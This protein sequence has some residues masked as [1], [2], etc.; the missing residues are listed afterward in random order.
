MQSF[1]H[2]VGVPSFVCLQQWCN[3]NMLFNWF[4]F[5]QYLWSWVPP[6]GWWSCEIFPKRSAATRN[7]HKYNEQSSSGSREICLVMSYKQS[8]VWQINILRHLPKEVRSNS[9]S[10]MVYKHKY[11]RQWSWEICCEMWGKNTSTSNETTLLWIWNLS[12]WDF[13]L[14]FAY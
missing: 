2:L 13:K 8:K 5:L 14:H 7:N 6:S 11:N 12:L 10:T 9:K 3:A 1:G 4:A